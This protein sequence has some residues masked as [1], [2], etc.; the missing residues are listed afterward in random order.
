MS[1]LVVCCLQFAVDCC[2]VG[3]GFVVGCCRLLPLLLAVVCGHFLVFSFV[4][5][6]R[7]L[8]CI[9]GCLLPVVVCS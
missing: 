7:V 6:G 4:N 3:I 1:L 5:S 8:L 9:I 2:Y